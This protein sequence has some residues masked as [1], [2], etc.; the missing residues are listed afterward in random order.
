MTTEKGDEQTPHYEDPEIEQMQLEILKAAKT[1][2]RISSANKTAF[3]GALLYLDVKAFID[4]GLY[5]SRN[6]SNLKAGVGAVSGHI[7]DV[8]DSGEEITPDVLNDLTTGVYDIRLAALPEDKEDVAEI[9]QDLMD[10]G[11]NVKYVN[12]ES[13]QLYLREG[14]I[15]TK[16][17]LAK[18]KDQILGSHAYY[19]APSFFLMAAVALYCGVQGLRN[20]YRLFLPKVTK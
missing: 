10:L 2:A 11:A 14:L 4:L 9:K 18:I 6:L 16:D 8:I 12:V 20:L 15:D 7:D 19:V 13:Q 17:Q 3:Y 1:K 5:A